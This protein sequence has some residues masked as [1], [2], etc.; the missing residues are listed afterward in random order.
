MYIIIGTHTH[1]YIKK[2]TDK[3]LKMVTLM[4][5]VGE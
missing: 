3:T 1:T 4:K 2:P 5:K